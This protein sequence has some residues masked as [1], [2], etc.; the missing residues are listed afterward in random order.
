MR[1]PLG[2]ILLTLLISACGGS[3]TDT[4]VGGI[5]KLDPLL[6][7]QV[8][9]EDTV[10]LFARRPDGPPMPLA[11]QRLQVKDMPY[12]FRLDDSQAMTETK[13]SSVDRVVVVARV[14]RTGQ[15]MPA[16]GDLEGRSASVPTGTGDLEIVIDRVL[17]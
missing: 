10:F 5:V 8:T 17:P 9:P 11:V 1:H 6:A 4:G 3:N 15:A 14:S 16:P 13:L 2:W 12:R 7:A